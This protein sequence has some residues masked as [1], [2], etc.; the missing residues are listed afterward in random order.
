MIRAPGHRDGAALQALHDDL[1][2]RTRESSRCEA[3]A[4]EQLREARAVECTGA[5]RL[6]QEAERV[7]T[8]EALRLSGADL[9][10]LAFRSALERAFATRHHVGVTRLRHS[11]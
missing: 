1:R 6:A 3:A 4:R 7:S 5:R 9:L 2:E 10:Q 11:S 8:L